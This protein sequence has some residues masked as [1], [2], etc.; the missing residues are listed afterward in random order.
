MAQGTW[1][2]GRTDVGSTANAMGTSPVTDNFR[3]TSSGVAVGTAGVVISAKPGRLYRLI[4]QNG[5]ATAY[6]LQIHN[7]ATAPINTEVPVYVKRLPVSSEV[8]IDLSDVNGL[9]CTAGIGLAISST[10]GTLTLAVADNIAFYAAFYT[11]TNA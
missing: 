9:V 10:A 1:F 8:E 7:K 4:V 6:Y 5:A 2:Q 3:R 11:A